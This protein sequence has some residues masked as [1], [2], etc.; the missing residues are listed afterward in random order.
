MKNGYRYKLIYVDK[1]S[2]VS[3][4]KSILIKYNEPK[5]SVIWQKRNC[6]LEFGQMIMNSLIKNGLV[7]ESE[8][9]E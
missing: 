4:Q 3:F 1:M 8:T 7:S 9:D 6:R 2:D 5:D